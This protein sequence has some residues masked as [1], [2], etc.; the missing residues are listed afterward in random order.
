MIKIIAA[1]IVL[2]AV[3]TSLPAQSSG[4]AGTGNDFGPTSR[5]TGIANG[6][7]QTRPP[8]GSVTYAGDPD[9]TRGNV[10]RAYSRSWYL[11]PLG[12]YILPVLILAV[13]LTFKQ[14]R[15]RMMHDT[16]RAMIEK[17]MPV[18]PELVASLKPS[19]GRGHLMCYLLPGLI[20]SAVGIGM[21]INGGRAGLIPLLIGVAF[22]I[23]WQV[24]KRSCQ[25][26][27]PPKE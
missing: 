18:T 15:T 9:S 8:E 27:Q 20:C 7:Y 12:F 1:A 5:S 3:A 21:M 22:L 24:E 19:D 11:F 17:G 26:N 16:L 4:P 6:G 10:Q 23:A 13:V 14:R 25:T 2:F